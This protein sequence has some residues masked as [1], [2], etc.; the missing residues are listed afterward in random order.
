M[1]QIIFLEQY[2]ASINESSPINTTILTVVAIDK[3]AG[4]NAVIRYTIAAGNDEVIYIT[5]FI[6]IFDLSSYSV[7]ILKASEH[8]CIFLKYSRNLNI[9]EIL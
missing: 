7:F 4:D 2:S 9:S 6:F 3:D 5:V 1:P 8:E